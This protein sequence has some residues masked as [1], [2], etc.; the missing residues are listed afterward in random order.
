[1]MPFNNCRIITNFLNL[2]IAN[3][4]FLYPL[5]TLEKRKIFWCFQEIEKVCIGNEW[6]NAEKVPRVLFKNAVSKDL[7]YKN[8][9]KTVIYYLK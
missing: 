6:V 9:Q 5:E 7:F 2:F 8:L 1:M 4:T 3:T